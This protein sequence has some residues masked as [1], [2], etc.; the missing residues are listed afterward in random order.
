MYDYGTKVYCKPLKEVGTI[1]ERNYVQRNGS[2]RACYVVEF[3]PGQDFMCG[4]NDLYRADYV[5]DGCSNWRSGQPE[6]VSE[7]RLGDGTVDDRFGFC[8]ICVQAARRDGERI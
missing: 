2:R 8:F 1:T 5:C 4:S 7:V 6:E 3:A